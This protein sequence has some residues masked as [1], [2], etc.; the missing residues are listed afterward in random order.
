MVNKAHDAETYA[1]LRLKQ[2]VDIALRY[3][4]EEE[5]R[6]IVEAEL[7]QRR[8]NEKVLR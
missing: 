7:N 4:E 5:V 3:F 6:K 8:S 1:S 2:A